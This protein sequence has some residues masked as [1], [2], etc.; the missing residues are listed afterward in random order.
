MAS[1]F[2]PS[3]LAKVSPDFTGRCF[4]LLL[5][6]WCAIMVGFACSTPRG[7]GLWLRSIEG[8]EVQ[9]SLKSFTMTHFNPLVCRCFA[10]KF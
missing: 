5:L 8:L 2:A 3:K 7:N 1:T 9:T 10:E 4:V 6:K